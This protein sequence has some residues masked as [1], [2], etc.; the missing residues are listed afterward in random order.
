MI[1]FVKE[2]MKNH[3]KNHPID[4]EHDEGKWGRGI[5]ILVQDSNEREQGAE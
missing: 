1:Q 4:G 3:G 5:W 2:V